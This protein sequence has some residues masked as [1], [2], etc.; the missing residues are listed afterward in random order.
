MSFS[1]IPRPPDRPYPSFG[2]LGRELC[3]S[4]VT[5]TASEQSTLQEV[6]IHWEFYKDT[7]E[8]KGKGKCYKRETEKFTISVPITSSIASSLTVPI[9]APITV[10]TITTA[11]GQPTRRQRSYGIDAASKSKTRWPQTSNKPDISASTP[12]T[13]WLHSSNEADAEIFGKA[14]KNAEEALNAAMKALGLYSWP[15]PLDSSA[16]PIAILA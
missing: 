10:P 14:E 6:I 12:N 15:K 16:L 1:V 3:A 13:R 5:N 8:E 7:D 9:V 4:S 11:Q 2:T